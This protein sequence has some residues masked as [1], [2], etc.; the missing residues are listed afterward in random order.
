MTIDSG[1]GIDMLV[2]FVVEMKGHPIPAF[3][4]EPMGDESSVYVFD[5]YYT[6]YDTY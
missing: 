3:R 5:R 1:V 6:Q 2:V 4:S